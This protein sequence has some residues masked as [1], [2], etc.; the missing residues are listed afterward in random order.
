METGRDRASGWRHAKLSGHENESDVE[1][2]FKDDEF[3]SKFSQ[4]I[5]IGEIISANVGGLRETDV[6]SVLGGKTKSKTDLTLKLV[7]GRNINISIKKS[8]G[9]QVY[10]IGVERF[11]SGYEKQFG[12]VIPDDIKKLLHIY[13][14]GSPQTKSLLEEPRVTYGENSKLIAYQQEHNRLVWKYLYNWDRAKADA[15]LD[16]FKGNIA[17]ISQFCFSRGLARDEK[18]WAQ[19][20]WYI[21]LLGEEDFDEIFSIEDICNAVESN[22]SEIYP[23]KINGGSTTQ[24]PFGFVQWHQQ[25][26]Q[27]HHSLGKLLKIVDQTL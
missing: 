21:N 14:Y 3:R 10:L 24:L 20:V 19:Y 15:L 16:W 9:G 23:S 8:C 2:L 6:E 26:M 5:G 11:I 22:L 18:D 12:V 27:F 4:R 17:N 25:Q 1:S 13:F 7:D